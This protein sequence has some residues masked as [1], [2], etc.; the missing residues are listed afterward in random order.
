MGITSMQALLAF[1]IYCENF[2]FLYII[3][4]M[5]LD[6]TVIMPRKT[7]YYTNLSIIF[8]QPHTARQG[9]GGV[10]NSSYYY[11][12]TTNTPTRGILW[13]VTVETAC[14][15]TAVVCDIHD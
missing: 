4:P 1:W 13:L 6:K 7:P 14:A 12:P 9:G 15:V 8:G 10:K 5:L 3:S 2:L 11:V